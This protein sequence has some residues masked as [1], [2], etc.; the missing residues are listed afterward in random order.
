[1]FAQNIYN[2]LKVVVPTVDTVD[3]SDEIVQSALTTYQGEIVH[4]GTLEAMNA[5]G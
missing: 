5:E 2:L 4:Q 1:M 3:V